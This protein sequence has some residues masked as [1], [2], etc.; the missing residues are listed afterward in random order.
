MQNLRRHS[1]LGCV[2]KPEKLECMGV[3][4]VSK[5][6]YWDFSYIVFDEHPL[7]PEIFINIENFKKMC[8]KNIFGQYKH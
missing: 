7:N 5:G 2:L 4:Y 1:V 6:K 3:L 8:G